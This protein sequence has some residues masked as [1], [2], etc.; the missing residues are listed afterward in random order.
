M[1]A[2]FSGLVGAFRRMH[3]NLLKQSRNL[4]ARFTFCINWRL[5]WET[6][7][8]M[9]K[10]FIRTSAFSYSFGTAIRLTCF[11]STAI[12]LTPRNWSLRISP[13]LPAGEFTSPDMGVGICLLFWNILSADKG[14]TV[15]A[16][17]GTW[18][19]TKGCVTTWVSVN[20]CR[21]MYITR[22]RQGNLN[23]YLLL[24]QNVKRSTVCFVNYYF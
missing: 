6:E 11:S 21:I 17:D 1:N 12:I 20:L 7:W 19:V 8:Y 18:Q 15:T 10:L 3:C 14:E 2:V 16:E 23:L 24:L 22:I 13:V 5:A 9:S 4:P